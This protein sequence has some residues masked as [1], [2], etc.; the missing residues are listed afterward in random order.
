MTVQDIGTLE[1]M[2]GNGS[3]YINAGNSKSI[4][5]DGKA[6]YT[7]AWIRGKDIKH[8]RVDNDLTVLGDIVAD[9]FREIVVAGNLKAAGLRATKMGIDE[10][11]VMGDVVMQGADI[12]GARAWVR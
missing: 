10:L 12:V 2:G 9:R 11:S 7:F 3:A 4:L 5:L 8:F 6:S 1:L